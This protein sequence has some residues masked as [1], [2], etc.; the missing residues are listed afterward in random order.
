LNR[1]TK[2]YQ[3][4]DLIDLN[5]SI[6]MKKA[7]TTYNNTKIGMI[8]A[9]CMIILYFAS[10][11]VFGCGGGVVP[12]VPT[13]SG[14]SG[15][16]TSGSF[17]LMEKGVAVDMFDVKKLQP[18]FRNI[19]LSGNERKINKKMGKAIEKNKKEGAGDST[20]VDTVQHTGSSSD[21][22]LPVLNLHRIH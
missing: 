13:Q 12:Y 19:V 4:D 1:D 22:T 6:G 20:N 3:D 14:A 18:L 17:F 9:A 7:Y 8:I 11:S 5:W 16:S 21:S 2:V 10:Y 15:S